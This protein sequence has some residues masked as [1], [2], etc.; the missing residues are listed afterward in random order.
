MPT[1]FH[2][3]NRL[4]VGDVVRYNVVY[5]P[6]T[7]TENPPGALYFHIRNTSSPV[8][9][10]AYLVGPYM[11]SASVASRAYDPHKANSPEERPQFD[12][13][14]KAGSC[15][16]AKVALRGGRQ[17][18]VVDVVSQIIFTRVNVTF[19]I[20]IGSSIEWNDR[21]AGT[22][23]ISVVCQNTD[24]LWRIPK[25]PPGIRNAHLVVVTHGLHSNVTADI[26]YLKQ[27]L[28]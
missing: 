13:Q 1:Y 15:F 21:Y 12:S 14:I 6:C 2:A 20:H 18:W 17:Q 11:F 22:R 23:E 10:A 24:E 3:K 25:F 8:Y 7:S 19:E 27:R 9:R 28:Q 16:T 5:S 26:F 4:G